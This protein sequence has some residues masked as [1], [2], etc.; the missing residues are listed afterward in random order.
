[1]KRHIRTTHERLEMEPIKNVP[2]ELD[3]CDKLFTSISN[4]QRHVR[5]VHENPKVYKCT[6]CE[7]KFTQKLK[8]RRHEISKHTGVFP[9]N[10]GKCDRGFYQKWQWE[11]HEE[12]CKV[13]PCPGCE[14]KFDKWTLFLKHCKESQ[15]SRKY[16]KCDHCSRMY[17]KPGELQKHVAAKHL[18]ADNSGGVYKCSYENCQKSYAYERNLR[19]HIATV[20]EGKKFK[21]TQN[22]CD[23]EFSSTQNL[24]KHL[25]RDHRSVTT[26]DDEPSSTT[27]RP[28][29][30]K[31]RKDAGESK[32]ANLAK[33]SGISVDKD[34]NKRLKSREQDALEEV[35]KHLAKEMD[36]SFESE[37]DIEL[38]LLVQAKNTENSNKVLQETE[39]TLK[40]FKTKGQQ[41]KSEELTEL[42][43]QDMDIDSISKEVGQE[44][45]NENF[46]KD[47]TI[48]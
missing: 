42:S 34:L 25:S 40:T 39:E 10:C 48:Q 20:H 22:D 43:S 21:C 47:L 38:I 27:K 45:N 12:T 29:K 14:L 9:Y 16:Y 32:V 8:M 35:T 31:K 2:C 4:M 44:E 13:Y 46:S 19:Q 37:D 18:E 15:H 24:Q 23:K 3:T 11:K 28:L 6:F 17:L 5:E 7:E 33:L 41:D 26:K 36:I 1:M 30:R